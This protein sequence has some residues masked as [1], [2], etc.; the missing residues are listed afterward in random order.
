[1]Y[2]LNELRRP[3]LITPDEVIFH[4]STK[5]TLDR[6]MIAQSIII[7]EER[8]IRPAL[9]SAFY[10]AILAEKNTVITA[11][12]KAT[13]QALVDEYYLNGKDKPKE[14]V[15]GDIVNASEYLSE[16]NLDLWMT[17]LWKLVAECVILTS[18]SDAFIQFTSEGPVHTQP[19]AGPLV[20]AGAVTP[21]LRSI[22]WTMDK[23]M[24]DRI[25]PL[26][27]AMHRW[28]C[29]ARDA[30]SD[31]FGLYTKKC[32]CSFNGVSYKRKSDFVFPSI[33]TTARPSYLDR[34]DPN[35]HPDCEDCD[36]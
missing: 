2:K 21:D 25:D 20:G 13:Q 10:D 34:R 19:T 33:Y 23:K 22:K 7:A 15:E 31:S 1:M 18:V 32:D 26:T 8:F 27:E 12:N 35:R 5:H 24:M 17:F 6:R 30:D 3:V 9:C 11:G 4:A 14:L 28:L 36:C 29:A 16:E